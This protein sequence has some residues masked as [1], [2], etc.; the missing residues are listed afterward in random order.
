MAPLSAD[1]VVYR[2]KTG[3]NSK[4]V[5][6]FTLQLVLS[7]TILRKLA[8]RIPKLIL[9]YKQ[10]TRLNPVK[11]H[12]SPNTNLFVGGLPSGGLNAPVPDSLLHALCCAWRARHLMAQKGKNSN[13]QTWE[14]A[15]V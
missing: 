3:E 15:V 10:Q 14:C 12:L 5:I 8:K 7:L 1:D 11:K 6:K 9:E 2:D 13:K 4:Q